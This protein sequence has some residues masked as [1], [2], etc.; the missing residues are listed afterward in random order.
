MAGAATML[1]PLQHV[2][3]VGCVGVFLKG[4]SVKTGGRKIFFFPCLA[5]PG[6]EE[7]PQCCLKRHRLSLF[8]YE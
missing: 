3:S 2:E 5:R 4:K 1:P 6:E 7:D 8:L